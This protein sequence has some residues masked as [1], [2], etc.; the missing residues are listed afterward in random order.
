MVKYEAGTSRDTAGTVQALQGG[1][2]QIL[3]AQM[4]YA[5]Q[6]NALGESARS[7]TGQIVQSFQQARERREVMDFQRSQQEDKQQHDLA[8]QRQEAESKSSLQQQKGAQESQQMH[9]KAKLDASKDPMIRYDEQAGE[10]RSTEMGTRTAALDYNIK[11]RE[12]SILDQRIAEYQGKQDRLSQQAA[13][14][15]AKDQRDFEFKMQQNTEDYI[16][17][18]HSE[19]RQLLKGGESALI[20]ALGGEGVDRKTPEGVNE[21]LR[22]SHELEKATAF[23]YASKTGDDKFIPR[24]SPEYEEYL[25]YRKP[26]VDQ[27]SQMP[28]LQMMGAN[29]DD[30]QWMAK[31]ANK[32]AAQLLLLTRQ[33]PQLRQMMQYYQGQ[34]GAGVQQPGLQGGQQQQRSDTGPQGPTGR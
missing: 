19:R 32:I 13:Q 30:S 6:L 11:R 22:R 15:D 2:A 34:G 5:Q 10:Y 16:S 7:G 33:N 12:K 21:M 14:A 4:A 20:D 29:S 3:Q 31:K 23:D 24:S 26:V 25:Q 9:A 28:G 17:K 8:L 27:L 1:T 18:L